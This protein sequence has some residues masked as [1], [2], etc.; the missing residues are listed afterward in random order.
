MSIKNLSPSHKSDFQQ[1]YYRPLNPHKYIGSEK[2]I[3]YR[4]SWEKKFMIKCD[5][6][7]DVLFWSSEPVCIKYFSTWD[8][9]YHNYYP[10]FYMKVQKQNGKVEEFLVEIKPH[11]QIQKPRPP[12][13]RSK[14]ALENYRFLAEQYI[15]NRD[16]YNYAKKWAENRDWR[17]IVMTEKSLK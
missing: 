3:I 2:S 4:S 17:F 7:E 8:N 10:D 15:K 1:G 16:K 5:N 6:R 13:K 14:K 11:Q 9:K 12:K